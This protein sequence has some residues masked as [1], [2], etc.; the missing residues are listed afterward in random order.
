MFIFSKREVMKS[1]SSLPI[2]YITG[3][4]SAISQGSDKNAD[5]PT[6]SRTPFQI[7]LNESIIDIYER[8]EVNT[9]VPDERSGFDRRTSP[10]RRQS[11]AKSVPSPS[12]QRV[13]DVNAYSPK[14]TTTQ[15]YDET[16]KK[17]PAFFSP[18]SEKG[19]ILDTWA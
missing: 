11:S 19:S 1:Q 18:S 13:T 15:T 3:S 7:S 8:S 6:T 10:G 9:A 17:M 2:Q 12:D 4:Q 16:A 14:Q 5:S